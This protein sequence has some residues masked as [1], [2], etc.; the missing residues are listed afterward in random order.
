MKIPLKNFE[1]NLTDYS[2]LWRWK[3]YFQDDKVH[4]LKENRNYSFEAEVVWSEDYEVSIKLDYDNNITAL[5]CDCPYD[6]WPICKH[7]I[8]VLYKLREKF[9]KE[10]ILVVTKE[11]KKKLKKESISQKEDTKA[12]FKWIIK[13][14]INWASKRRW[15]VERDRIDESLNWANN[16]ISKIDDLL[17][18]KDFK[19]AILALSILI[20]TLI[21]SLQNVDDS[22]WEYWSMIEFECIE[23]YL[24]KLIEQIKEDWNKKDFD[25]LILEFLQ[26]VQNDKIS[27]FDFEYQILNTLIVWLNKENYKDFKQALDFVKNKDSFNN[28][29]IIEYRMIQTIWTKDEINKFIKQNLKSYSFAMIIVDELINKR[30]F[31]QAIIILKNHLEKREY[32]NWDILKK[33]LNISRL[34]KNKDDEKKYLFEI[35]LDSSDLSSFN[36][37][38]KF[39]WSDKYSTSKQEIFN[40]IDKLKK[41]ANS[42]EYPDICLQEKEDK[43]FLDYIFRNP[44]ISTVDRF[45]TK[46]L[47]TIPDELY[48]IYKNEVEENLIQ[49]TNRKKYAEQCR[50]IRKMKKIFPDK[51]ID[52]IESLKNKYY[53]RSALKEELDLV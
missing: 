31:E 9:I 22:S 46:L 14:S 48:N 12:Y 13:E 33:L 3:D 52:F 2:T 44:Y 21:I 26:L 4:N 20:E 10:K 45:F 7:E 28:Y 11:K 29:E 6:Y 40:K 1:K 19:T 37:Y 36:E 15:Y 38:K 25:T 41:V 32:N 24:N 16:I 23:D 17:W 8:A 43:R 50:K 35:F 5:Y 47:K 49:T 51:T 42:R 18:Q 30:E 39:L 34:T 53:Q 27:W